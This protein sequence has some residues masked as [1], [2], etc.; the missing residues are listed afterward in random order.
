MGT[1]SCTHKFN[2]HP[3]I[4]RARHYF[5]IFFIV[6]FVIILA[7][8]MDYLFRGETGIAKKFAEYVGD[9]WGIGV[10]IG[11]GIF[12]ILL[13]SLPFVPGVELGVLLM[14]IFGKE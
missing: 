7:F 9:Q 2:P 12:Y 4:S 10:L 3:K 8:W 11:G 13:L 14:C 6:T 5:H 1:D